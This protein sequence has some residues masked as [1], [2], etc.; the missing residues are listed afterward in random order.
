MDTRGENHGTLTNYGQI[1]HILMKK[2]WRNAIYE[3]WSTPYA[4]ITS[5]HYPL[6]GRLKIKFAR[7]EKRS[8]EGK[9]LVKID[10]WKTIQEAPEKIKRMNEEM[11]KKL[12]EKNNI[13]HK[14]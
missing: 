12:R 7:K 11:R 9:K 4:C 5:D 2:R 1:D 3:V 10:H 8:P 14:R 6:I 13:T